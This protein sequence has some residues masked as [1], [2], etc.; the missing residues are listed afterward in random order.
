MPHDSQIADFI[1][2]LARK[3]ACS[4]HQARRIF[5]EQLDHARRSRITRGS[6]AVIHHET[7]RKKKSIR[8]DNPERR[9]HEPS[10]SE[11]KKPAS[12]GQVKSKT[13]PTE[14][15][16]P[17]FTTGNPEKQKAPALGTE[18]NIIYTAIRDSPTFDIAEIKLHGMAQFR[19]LARWEL[20]RRMYSVVTTYGLRI[21]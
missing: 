11:S 4:I 5:L 10:A 15:K 16:S 12:R 2:H 3:H 18:S 21:K 14:P 19:Y 8:L 7:H 17:P 13:D 6:D 1:A 20:R 9:F